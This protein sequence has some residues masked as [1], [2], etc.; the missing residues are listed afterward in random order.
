MRVERQINE[1]EAATVRRI[2]ARS[3]AGAG[4]KVIAH[5]L[6]AAG[7]PAPCPRRNSRPHGWAPSSVREI[8]HRETYRGVVV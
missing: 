2:F 1:A 5:E 3:E 4:L 8:L 6:N 7:A